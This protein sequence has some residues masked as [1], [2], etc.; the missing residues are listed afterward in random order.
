MPNYQ[1]YKNEL[2]QNLFAKKSI[3][4][5]GLLLCLFYV[6]IAFSLPT[7]SFVDDMW[8]WKEWSKSSF[9]YGIENI[10]STNTYTKTNYHPVWLYILYLYGQIQGSIEE[11]NLNI[12]YIKLVP[13]FFDFLGAVIVFHFIKYR[14]KNYL[15]PF[16]L[17]FNIAYLYN[18]IFWGQIDSIPT[19]FALLSIIFALKTRVSLSTLFFI[20]ALNTK[21]QAIIF[22][23]IIGLLLLPQII[24]KPKRILN[25]LFIGILTQI[26]I[27][28]PFLLAGT[29]NGYWHVLTNAV[30]HHPKISMNAFNIW[31]LLFPNPTGMFDNIPFW[32]ATPRFWGLSLFFTFS[33]ITLL[34]LLIR[35]IQKIKTKEISL[36]DLSKM[37]FL[38]CGL[39]T[40]VFFFFNTQMHERYTHSA[41]IFFFFYGVLSKNYWLYGLTSIAYF[42]NLEKVLHSFSFFNPYT[43][44]FNPRYI[45]LIY[46]VILIIGIWK[47]YKPFSFV[48]AFN[49]K[50]N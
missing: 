50:P 41:L 21:L 45:A 34:P 39:I 3:L 44:I 38:I 31:Y 33:F 16:F 25:I 17:L 37:V 19:F 15:L 27:I 32:L 49:K 40:I 29:A 20:I 46:L 5:F 24:Q 18:S 23:P 10:Y 36:F 28:L 43:F 7:K 12:N 35:I 9:E 42:L 26:V 4:S 8:F 1:N 13:L 14:H 30:G 2:L 6:L 22:F 48:F 47:L 11:I